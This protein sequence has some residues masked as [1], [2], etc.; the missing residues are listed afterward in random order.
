MTRKD[1]RFIATIR[2]WVLAPLFV[3]LLLA[4]TLGCS[5]FMAAKQPDAKDLSVLEQG[6]PRA[7]VITELGAPAWSEETNG[8]KTDLFKFKQGYSKGAKVGRAF[9]HGAADVLT[10]GL[11]EVVGTPAES[12]F[13]GTDMGVK[14]TYDQND[15]VK[16]SRILKGPSAAPEATEEPTDSEEAIGS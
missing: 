6:T 9:F 12:Y 8:G 4:P 7:H 13:S 3:T 16:T 5:V 2:A 14:V 15:R 11:W 10:F 1:N